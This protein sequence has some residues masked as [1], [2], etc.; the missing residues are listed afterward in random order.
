LTKRRGS[1]SP[2]ERQIA[3]R[4]ASVNVA[5]GLTVLAATGSIIYA[6][7]TWEQP[8]RAALL[9]LASAA[10][11]SAPII[12]ALPRRRI[13]SGSWREPF[14]VSW[15]VGL[16]ACIAAATAIDGG[17]ASPY[18]AL[19]FLPLI[20]AGL[21]YP[22][23]SVIVVAVAD[24]VAYAAVVV[25]R[26]GD[27]VAEAF[28]GFAIACGALMCV[29]QAGNRVRQE[30][31][32]IETAE[33]LRASEATTRQRE[34]QQ[35]EIA[36]FGQRALAGRSLETLMD[37]VATAVGRALDADVVS[38]LELDGEGRALTIRAGIGMPDDVMGT[39]PVPTGGRSQAGY[40]LDIGRPVIVEDWEAETRFEKPRILDR[41]DAVSGVTVP[42]R[43]RGEPFG[44]LGVQTRSR[45]RFGEDAVNFMQSM[46]NSLA[47]A[48]DR[49]ADEEEARERAL[50][51]PLTWLPN[52]ALFAG[53][54]TTAL[55]RQARRGGW[56]AVI[57]L[58]LDRFKL[59]NDG[60][61]HQAGDEL[62]KEVAPRLKE[63]V[64]PGDVV[65]RFGGD[66]FAVLLDDIGSERDATRVAERIASGLSS[67]FVIAGREH[68]V[69]ASMGIALGS[70]EDQSES[71]IRDADAAM[72]RAK[73]LGR[74]RYEMFD[75]NMRFRLAERLRVEN[76]LR[77]GID[78]G[79]LCLH[80]QP[81]V[82][83][84]SGRVTGAEALV[85]WEHPERG[86]LLPAEFIDVAEESG[87]V[88]QLG[89]WVLGEACR[90]VALWQNADP[91]APPMSMAVNVS[92]R[93]LSDPGFP[94]TV[95]RVMEATAI[96]PM[97]LTL[98]LTESLVMDQNR[99]SIGAL[100]ALNELGVKLSLDDFGTGYSSLA[101]LQRL[102]LNV[103]KLDRRFIA[104]VGT[105][106]DD[107]IVRAV[108][109]LG[110][111]MGLPVVA[112]G[113][114]T[115]EQL[116][117]VTELGCQYAQGFY[118]SRPV[119]RREFGEL[120]RDPDRISARMSV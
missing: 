43:G 75:Q 65:A 8:D 71:L 96:E 102:P 15:T 20:F 61:G 85:R 23:R 50:H 90:Q 36:T 74:A 47:S 89:D 45:R 49:R 91:D 66:E 77:A 9:F 112:E 106:T 25:A 62:L 1:K 56:A 14:F 58:D 119:D 87:L 99:S 40:T 79:E 117:I 57:F 55:A 31:E 37:D 69:S 10:F 105:E 115:A 4:L 86:L 34:M 46:A 68:F 5:L 63:A 103:I 42:I 80:Y 60:L 30:E 3:F 16:I 72:Y 120:L 11:V 24:V 53:H 110:Q 32:L 51:D 111:S 35:A 70:S 101:Y 7:A 18:R 48:I 93:Q 108:V 6:L 19:F 81:V 97:S 13:V 27:V 41:L 17:L 33:A 82:E 83:L 52:R 118:F 107:A 38:V 59:I 109:A 2:I 98:E 92:A 113:V 12:L 54:L 104:R 100:G 67:P 76:E 94:H 29:W 73:E 28:V 114:E 22:P 64:R 26:P 116:A 88:R 84:R 95:R 21:S 39:S 44:V 78:R